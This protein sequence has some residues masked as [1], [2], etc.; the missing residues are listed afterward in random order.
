MKGHFDVAWNDR[1]QL[2]QPDGNRA[3]RTEALNKWNIT[4][5]HR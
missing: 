3:A 2:G 4:V 5:C 1:F